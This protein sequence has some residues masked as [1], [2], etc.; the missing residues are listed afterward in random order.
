MVDGEIIA[1]LRHK[2]EFADVLAAEC[3]NLKRSVYVGF[4]WEM[5]SDANSVQVGRWT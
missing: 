4:A 1:L 3:V 2:N 5:S